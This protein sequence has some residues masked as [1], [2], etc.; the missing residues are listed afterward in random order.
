[1]VSEVLSLANLTLLQDLGR[2][3]GRPIAP[4][5]LRYAFSDHGLDP[6]LSSRCFIGLFSV[7]DDRCHEW[8]T[9]F[10]EILQCLC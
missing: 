8:Q 6:L 9:T 4:H 5:L 1:M 2:M 7:P 10:L 3:G